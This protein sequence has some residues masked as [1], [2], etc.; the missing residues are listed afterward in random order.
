ML[1][2]HYLS[3]KSKISFAWVDEEGDTIVLSTEEELKE[4]LRIMS[5]LKMDTFKFF[6][7]HRDDEDK[8]MEHGSHPTGVQNV[9]QTHA[10]RAISYSKSARVRGSTDRGSYEAGGE[11]LDILS[12]YSSSDGHEDGT[13]L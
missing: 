2:K 4:A 10:T 8:P 3:D 12:R 7:V 13:I 11:F 5:S 6:V 9:A 1:Y